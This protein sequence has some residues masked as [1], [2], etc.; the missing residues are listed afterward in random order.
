MSTASVTE[1]VAFDNISGAVHPGRKAKEKDKIRIKEYYIRENM[2]GSH[3]KMNKRRG[4]TISLRAG[5]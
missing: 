3:K 1:V 4:V 2:I 5:G